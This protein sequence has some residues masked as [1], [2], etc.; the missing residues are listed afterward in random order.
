VKQ[1]TRQKP[2][3]LIMDLKERKRK[4]MAAAMRQ[5]LNAAVRYVKAETEYLE[6]KKSTSKLMKENKIV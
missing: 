4:A 2:T 6:P 5:L 3:R 1:K